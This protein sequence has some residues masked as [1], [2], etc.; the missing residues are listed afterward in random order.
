MD[1]KTLNAANY[2][3]L[4][5]EL[6]KDSLRPRYHFVPPANWLNDPNG[7]IYWQ[8]EYHIFY[9]HN[10]YAASWGRIHW[11]H[12]VS[13]D[14]LHWRDL[15]IALT[16]TPGTYDADGCW[17]G[18]AVDND[19]VP[20]LIYTG[21]RGEAE[22]ICLA[23]SRDGLVTWEK[24]SQNPV[25]TDPPPSL[26]TVGF[27]DP[28]V[29]REDA[30]WR[31]VIGTGIAGRGGAVLLYRSADLHSWEYLGPLF[32]GDAIKPDKMWE[33]PNLFPLGDKHLLIVTICGGTG[34]R[35][36][37]GQYDGRYFLP[38][39]QGLVDG[40]EHFFAPLTFQGPRGRRLLFGWLQEGRSVAEQLA[41]GWA[42]LLTL[43]RELSLTP[44]AGLA[45]RPV[46]ELAQLRGKAL[47]AAEATS[48]PG[49]MVEIQVEF[50]VQQ[51]SCQVVLSHAAGNDAPI[52]A[53][54]DP[55][56]Q[57]FFLSGVVGGRLTAPLSL[58][59]GEKLKLQLFYDRSV[60][61]VFANA[62]L[63]LTGRFYP[64]EPASPLQL[65]AQSA[66]C[67][68]VWPLAL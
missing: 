59:C 18:C 48:L 54:Y 13:T 49:G 41:A 52:S 57:Q 65:R 66:D 26:E 37:V 56:A 3:A 23:T 25:I 16:P 33:C 21:R 51:E 2:A 44:E 15:P 11:G 14:L 68:R 47:S 22:S 4:R 20:T 53:G 67:V 45:S 28:F 60:V 10:P 39:R 50:T 12:A 5:A 64:A 63:A 17:S 6:S 9:Q 34:V 55:T 40:G 27:R 61:E 32:I 7:L 1:F 35:Y 46:T 36:F 38:E 42:G 31:M 24:D 19:G 8:G 43:P 30:G 29:W 62:E 58:S